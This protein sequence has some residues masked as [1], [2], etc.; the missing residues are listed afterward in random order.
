M[1]KAELLALLDT[2][3]AHD[4]PPPGAILQ[5]LRQVIAMLADQWCDGTQGHEPTRAWTD[6]VTR[7]VYGYY[8]QAT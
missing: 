6:V 3:S 8:S 7:C 2:N 5:A 4:V 1:K